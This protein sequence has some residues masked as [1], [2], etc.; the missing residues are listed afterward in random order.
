M[1]TN[2]ALANL[3]SNITRSV[4]SIAGIA[5]AVILIFMQLGFRGAVE[6]TATTIYGKMDFD[7]L[8]RSKNYLHFVDCRSI[9]RSLEKQIASWDGVAKTTPF[10]V[11]M[12]NWL[13]PEGTRIRGIVIMGVPYNSRPFNDEEVVNKLKKLTSDKYVLM[14]R[15]THYEYGPENR[16]RFGDQDV[17]VRTNVNQ[18]TV[19]IVD[20]FEIGAG[21][22][23]NGSLITSE[24]GFN[25]LVPVDTDL[26][27]SMILVK[28]DANRNPI[29][30]AQALQKSL[31][32]DS[33]CQVFTRDEVISA[34]LT[35]WIDQTPLGFVFTLGV[36]VS[37]VVGSAIVF[38]VLSNDVANRL[39]EYATLK[40]MGYTNLFLSTIVLKQATYFAVF[41]FVPALLFSLGLY[42]VTSILANV[43]IEMT[44]LRAVSVFGI[45]IVMCWVSGFGALKKLWQAE[46]ASLF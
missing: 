29:E 21:L 13:H 12:G 4:I 30:V 26:D 8:V 43:S 37:F 34:E 22:T 27:V 32:A 36:A 28:L 39:P 17:G 46:P 2:L 9:S 33:E 5:I 18:M 31:P 45:S 15:K 41:A 38:M 23:A 11:S 35:R 20:H 3:Q 42:W 6:T 25:R 40:A 44:L 24:R 1:R 7:L 10:H 19:E 16:R 14:D